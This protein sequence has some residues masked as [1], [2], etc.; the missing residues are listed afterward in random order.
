VG[1]G[2]RVTEEYRCPECGSPLTIDPDAIVVDR[3]PGSFHVP[4]RPYKDVSRLA[5]VAFCTGCEWAIEIRTEG[6]HADHA[7]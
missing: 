6:D 2:G 1:A 4:G 7:L 3:V 5:P